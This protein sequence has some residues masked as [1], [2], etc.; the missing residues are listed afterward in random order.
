MDYIPVLNVR[1]DECHLEKASSYSY[2]DKSSITCLRKPLWKG[3]C[4]GLLVGCFVTFMGCLA[5][6]LIVFDGFEHQGCQENSSRNGRFAMHSQPCRAI[7]RV[8]YI[9]TVKF[10]IQVYVGEVITDN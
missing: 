1:D 8:S 4:V 9:S 6:G 10:V 3:F 5:V 7:I 2:E